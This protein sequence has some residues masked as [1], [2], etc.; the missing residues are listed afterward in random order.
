MNFFKGKADLR[1]ALLIGSMCSLSYLAVYVARNTLGAVSPQMIEGGVFTTGQIGTL[2]SLYFITY[3]IGQLVNGRIGDKITAKYMISVGLAAA[4]L[5]TL[6]IPLAVRSIYAVYIAYGASGFFLSMIYGPMTKVVA[7]NN[8]PVYATRCTLG[9]TVASFLGSPAAGLMAVVL[10]WQG[11]FALSSGFLLVMGL[12]CFIVFQIFE[13]MKIVRYNQFRPP[14]EKGG[15]IKILLKRGIVTFVM[16]SMITGIVRTSVVFWLPT[17]LSQQLGYSAE[18]AALLFTVATF[19]IS[20]S[21]FIAIFMYERV[22]RSN[23]GWTIVASFLF[24]TLFFAAVYLVKNSAFNTAMIVLAI[25]ASNCAATML[26]SRFCPSLRDTGMVS[27]ATGF[28]DF[29]SYVAA[30]VSSTLF[31]GTVSDIGWS[32]LILVWLGLMAAGAA[33]SL[34]YAL[35]TSRADSKTA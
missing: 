4:G 8:D 32:G 35:K 12:L 18:H 14:E 3:A 16:I 23:M 33:V 22:F 6:V 7:E 5:C 17:Y 27:S 24:A 9:Y 25:I 28:L 2:S 20:A 1:N 34:P 21:P 30:A 19:L 15:S 10:T 13:R 26:Y 29:A 31:A 11:V